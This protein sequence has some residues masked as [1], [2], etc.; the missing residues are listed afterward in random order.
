M[1][2]PEVSKLKEKWA[3]SECQ[4]CSMGDLNLYLISGKPCVE[5]QRITK[6]GSFCAVRPESSVRIKESQL[7]PK[8]DNL[9]CC[10]QDLR[11]KK[12]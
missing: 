7:P 3:N 11:S 12:Q 5:K 9:T 2:L 8:G 1:S 6:K 10:G 4:T